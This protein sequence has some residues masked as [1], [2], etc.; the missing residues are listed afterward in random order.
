[1]LARTGVQFGLRHLHQIAPSFAQKQPQIQRARWGMLLTRGVKHV[2]T[3]SLESR[4]AAAG[5][6]DLRAFLVGGYELPGHMMKSHFVTRP[7][8]VVVAIRGFKLN[9]T[10]ARVRALG[11]T[12][13]HPERQAVASVPPIGSPER[14]HGKKERDPH[15]HVRQVQAAEWRIQPQPM[16]ERPLTERPHDTIDPRHTQ[17]QKRHAHQFVVEGRLPERSKQ[18]IEGEHAGSVQQTEHKPAERS[19]R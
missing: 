12:R 1:M 2:E 9:Q 3:R 19:A 8:G 16:K 13:L 14:G 4:F 11:I 6:V 7:P 10:R 15:G 18:R 5:E 17:V